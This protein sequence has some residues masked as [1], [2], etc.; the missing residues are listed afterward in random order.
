MFKTFR[1][2]VT[3]TDAQDIVEYA[4]LAASISIT[5][6]VVLASIGVD[7]GN[8]YQRINTS[9]AAANHGS[10]TSGSPSSGGGGSS[11][12]DQGGAGA[13]SGS[14]GNGGTARR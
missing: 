2:L 1:H 4:F 7:V 9:V 11:G 14:G 5:A 12:G 13:G 3:R 6:L 8:G 10:G